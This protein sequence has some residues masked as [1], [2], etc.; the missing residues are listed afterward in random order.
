VTALGDVLHFAD[1]IIAERG[2]RYGP[3]GND[4]H[5]GLDEAPARMHT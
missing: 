4:P 1:R 5:L 3:R 2:V